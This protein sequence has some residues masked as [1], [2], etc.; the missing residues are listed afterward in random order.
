MPKEFVVV[1]EKMYPFGELGEV[2]AEDTK[3]LVQKSLKI[4]C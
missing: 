2:L 1:M 4:T 3:A